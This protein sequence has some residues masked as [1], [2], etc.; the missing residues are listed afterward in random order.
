MRKEILY[1][2][3]ARQKIADGIDKVANAVITT[4]GPK[5]R[6]VIISRSLPSPEGMKYYQPIV[7][8]DGVTV[9]RNIML[10]DY[11][12][13]VGCMMIREASEKTMQQAGDGT[14]TT[15]L[16]VQAIV[17]EGLK[18]LEEGANPQELKRGIDE[19]VA[20]VVSELK[21]NAIPVG[22]DIEKIKQIATVS[23]NNDSSIGEL[24]AEAFRVIGKDGI[25]DIEESKTGKT[26][27]KTSTGFKFE[28]GWKSPYFITN[29]ARS[30]CELLEPYILLYDKKLT[31][32]PP[33]GNILEKII[34]AGKS[35]LIICDDADGE[36]L[37]ALAMNASQGRIKCCIVQ[38]PGFGESKREAMEDIAVLTGAYFISD[39]KGIS[40]GSATF[41]ELGKASKVIVGKEETTI[42]GAE[43]NEK[44]LKDLLDNLKMDLVEQSEEER[45]KTEK[46][47]A[48][49]TGSV[50]VLHVGAATETEMKEKKDRCDDA[51][52]A[53]KAAISE[54]YV[55]G[56]GESFLKI[57][58]G[59]KIIDS[60][61]RKPLEQICKNA[62][63]E[64]MVD[65]VQDGLG[66]NAKSGVMENLIE[67]GIID[68]VKV[69]RC[70]LEN[71]ASTA[72][73]ILT[74]ETLICD[75]L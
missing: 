16:F 63:V 38:S 33:L 59:N 8:K 14:T 75:S 32:M 44:K 61:L 64:S 10:T 41:K 36:A 60:A 72:T 24:I 35:L 3:E 34:S 13:N 67:A 4:L 66:Y 2:S 1:G 39:E 73:M 31:T 37:A 22:D 28:K 70:S 50:A 29:H 58:S 45:E 7:T 27:I 21:K 51:V 42:I 5:G 71:A 17:K 57:K 23:A 55:A 18:L 49:L 30:E 40:L 11:L 19:A 12:E 26:E 68:P 43:S 9:A 20:Y 56:G 15:C 54:G 65:K 46:R 25:I 6:C 53:T 52:R 69:L 47:I 62:G 48:K 74:S